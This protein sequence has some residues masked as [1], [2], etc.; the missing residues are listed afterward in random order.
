MPL[1]ENALTT[2]DRLK[3]PIDDLSIEMY[4]NAASDV[5]ENY[6]N[7]KFSK[8]PRTL[9]L[10]SDGSKYL[11]INYWNIES[12]EQILNADA[13]ITDYTILAE[14]GMLY[15]KGGWPKLNDYDLEVNFTAG[16]IL[17]KDATEENPSTLPGGIENACIL[18]AQNLYWE[19]QR[20]PII[21]SQSRGGVSTKYL[22][23]RVTVYEKLPGAA[24]AL[25]KNWRFTPC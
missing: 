17:P 2:A 8:K 6:C 11:M 15:K 1:S 23:K 25:A 7:T 20:N 21:E 16:F 3:L 4:I 24:L 19:Q 22:S 12:V 13:E 10:K 18:I 9:K 14:K 5:L